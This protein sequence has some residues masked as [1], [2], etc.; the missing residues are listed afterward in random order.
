MT[1]E[2]PFFYTWQR[3]RGARGLE[4]TGGEGCHFDT[5]EGRFLDLGALVYQANAGHG[6]RRIIDAI[7]AQAD[8][9]CLSTP[10]SH[11][12]AKEELA[13][14]LL[15]AAPEGSPRSSSPWAAP[16]PTRTR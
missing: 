12:P 10:S 3:Q 5:P 9:L 7:K 15:A 13:R 6:H 16:T 2:S 8:Q 1:D 4:I 14:E 11:Y